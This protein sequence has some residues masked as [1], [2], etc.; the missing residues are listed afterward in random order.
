ML[1]ACSSQAI[2]D[3]RQH[4][5]NVIAAKLRN[6]SDIVRC[7]IQNGIMGIFLNV[8]RG[9]CNYYHNR[10]YQ[11]NPPQTISPV[12]HFNCTLYVSIF[13]ILLLHL[14]ITKTL[15]RHHS[16][17]TTHFSLIVFPREF[18]HQPRPMQ[19]KISV[20]KTYKG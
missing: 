10:P 6:Y 1:T 11:I 12:V 3:E 7:A 19:R 9:F 15:L 2:N 20:F 18:F 5:G 16:V 13:R 4:F 14:S 17:H 8:E